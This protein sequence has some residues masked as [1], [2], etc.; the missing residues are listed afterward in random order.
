LTEKLE[1]LLDEALAFIQ[2]EKF[3]TGLAALDMLTEVAGDADGN[4]IDYR[5]LI[6]E[7]LMQGDAEVIQKQYAVASMMA[8]R[9]DARTEKLL[10]VACLSGYGFSINEVVGLLGGREIDLDSFLREWSQAIMRKIECLGILRSG[11]YD[12]TFI[13]KM[14]VESVT[15]QGDAKMAEYAHEYG[16]THPILYCALVE[17]MISNGNYDDAI[18]TVETA[19]SVVDSKQSRISLADLKYDAGKA[20]GDVAALRSAA[21]QGFKASLSLQHFLRLWKYGDKTTKTEATEVFREKMGE[22]R[23]VVHILFIIGAY[24]ELWD[25]VRVDKESLGWSNSDR[26]YI[27]HYKAK[28]PRHRSFLESVR[29]MEKTF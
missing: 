21:M 15:L 25:M 20:T 9:G 6:E 29:T 19:L 2:I 24:K 16:K 8:L 11:M 26:R 17:S 10:Q 28:Y 12:V 27:D 14:L 7:G 4:V 22:C 5:D 18:K 3:E 1:P 13:G 23:D